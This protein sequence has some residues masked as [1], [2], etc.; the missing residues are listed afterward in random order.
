M[1]ISL[2]G[3]ITHKE[4]NFVVL[5]NNGVGCQIFMNAALAPAAGSDA[6]FFIYEHI[7]EDRHD[8]YG[9]LNFSDLEFFNKLLAVDGVGPRMAQNIGALGFD[10]VQKAVLE[11]NVSVIEAVHGVGKKTAQKI[12][13]E[14]KGS[15]DKI[16]AKS[17]INQDALS[18]LL[19][20]GYNRSEAEK[21]LGELSEEISG[22]GAQIK[23]ALKLLG[24]K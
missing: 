11:G 8:L 23:A 19:N 3:K 10:R 2:S 13:L 5:E 20:L 21:T 15:L 17:N 24:K 7:R 9:F 4:P 12:I 22:T 14:L 6:K 1:I 16:L 18:A